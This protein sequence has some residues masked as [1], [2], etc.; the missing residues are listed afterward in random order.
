[1]TSKIT[2][3]RNA[4]WVVA[5]DP[6]GSEHI[7]L[8][9]VDIAFQGDRIIHVGSHFT[10]QADVTIDGRYLLVMPG[11]I[12]IHSHP[13]SEPMN[14]GI[15]D[16]LG[17]PRLY[18]TSLYEYM[19]LFKPDPEGATAAVQVAYCELLM[20][21]VTTLVD[22]S[23][24]HSEWLDLMVKSGLRGVLAPSYRSAVWGTQNGYSVE[25][26]WDEAAGRSGMEA[27]MKL[28]D[29]AER[30]PSGRLSGMISPAQVDTCTPELLK[31][32]L[33]AAMEKEL[34]LQ[35]HAAQ[36]VVE[37]QEMVRRHG[38]T[39]IEWLHR[40]GLLTPRTII[41]HG[42]YLDHHSSINWYI[43]SDL[44]RLAR[45]GTSV[46][47]CPTVFSRRGMKLE[48]FGGYLAAGVNMGLGT[49]TYPHNMIEEIRAA[50]IF[51]RIVSGQIRP[52]TR[53]VFNA[54]PSVEPGR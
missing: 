5:W 24:P 20:S 50:I 7:Y 23:A 42:I 47:H 51:G 31:D 46:A 8:N 22:I 18:N 34:P 32:S 29:A 39:P 43:R 41:G 14:Q 28:I 35:I 48:D 1:M 33:D 15:N 26:I 37:F 38:L 4:D 6:D 53:E 2:L 27:A 9:D 54:A 36:S 13:A 21:G 19:P 49:D 52:M 30:H 11:L 25:Y 17:S 16:E 10:G 44:D 3:I 45:S 40:L 12:N